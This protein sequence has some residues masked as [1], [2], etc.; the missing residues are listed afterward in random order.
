MTSSGSLVT[1]DT[2]AYKIC[3]TEE[4]VNIKIPLTNTFLFQND[5]YIHFF[6]NVGVQNFPSTDVIHKWLP[7]HYSFVFVQLSLPSL[8]IM[9]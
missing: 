9:C 7:I 8:I 1:C 6:I 4:V 3:M 2:N 5:A